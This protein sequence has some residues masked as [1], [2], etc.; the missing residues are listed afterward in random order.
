MNLKQTFVGVLIAVSLTGPA[1]AQV[2][3]EMSEISCKQ[4]AGYD[5]E[6]KGF[7]ANWMRGYFNS[8]N[9]VSIIDVRDAKR[10][11]EKVLAYC[12]KKPKVSLM[13]AI[14]KNAQ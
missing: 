3:I 13:D 8:K 6:T 11:T 9:S 14:E 7:I 4:F 10:N 5:G 12:K 1:S 2:M